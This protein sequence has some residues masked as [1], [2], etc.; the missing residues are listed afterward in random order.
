M[1]RELTRGFFYKLLNF[2]DY[3]AIAYAYTEDYGKLKFFIGKAFTKK[4]SI[5]KVI[6][7]EIDFFKKANSDLNKFYNFRVF[8]DYYHYIEIK[9]I[10]LRLIII[11]EIIDML[12]PLEMADNYLFKLLLNVKEKNYT[13]FSIYT[14]YYILKKS[15]I[16]FDFHYCC[17]C[18][19]QLNDTLFLCDEGLLCPDCAIDF[20]IK[21]NIDNTDYKVIK[22]LEDK[23][24]FRFKDIDEDREFRLL[25]IFTAYIE[26]HT[27]KKIKSLSGLKI[28]R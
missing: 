15:G 17:K 21:K 27:N 12:Y 3:S 8:P 25:E 13:K 2:S 23:N 7:G 19:Q 28:F 14:I 22:I 24:A 26:M 6:P 18:G 16:I 10:Y 1:S 5:S 11:F 20:K 4:G 9:P